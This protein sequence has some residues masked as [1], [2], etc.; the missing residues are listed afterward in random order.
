MGGA[1]V[2]GT[3]TG[4]GWETTGA[5]GAPYLNDDVDDA[6]DYPVGNTHPLVP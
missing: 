5:R 4:T 6:D 3:G 1:V 2:A